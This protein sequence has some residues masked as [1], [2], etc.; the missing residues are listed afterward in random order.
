MSALDAARGPEREPTA[1]PRWLAGIIIGA[2]A[3]A[4]LAALL[5]PSLPFTQPPPKDAGVVRA[6]IEGEGVGGRIGAIA[7]DFEWTGS[8]G[9]PVR[10]SSY[11]G[12]VVVVN[13]WATWCLP[14]R[15][16]MPALQRIAA[17]EPDVVFLE[18]DLLETGDKVHSFFEQL[19]LDRLVPVLDTE[20]ETARRF[21]VFTLPS[22]FFIDKGGVIRHLE[23]GGP[24]SD[25]RIRIG[26]NK[27]R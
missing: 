13:F 17:G 25:E 7:P 14:C 18:V 26:I 19:A 12:K 24:L 16:E 20:A 4:S 22:T 21:G 9:K 5:W 11:R 27:A 3:L 23:I 6:Q 15:Q 10:L 1:L 2:I 8:D